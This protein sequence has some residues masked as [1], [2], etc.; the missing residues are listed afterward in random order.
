MGAVRAPGPV[1]ITGKLMSSSSRVPR[2]AKVTALQ[3]VLISLGLSFKLILVKSISG[4]AVS[5]IEQ[6]T[7]TY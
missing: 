7:K 6:K 2:G 5:K 3:L 1:L 4:T